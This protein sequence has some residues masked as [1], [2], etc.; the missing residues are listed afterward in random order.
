MKYYVIEYENGEFRHGY[1]NSYS[2]ALNYAESHN[3]GY[4]Y[5]ISEYDSEE[6]YLNSL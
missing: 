4:E 5:T 1:F 2:E 6:D 3:G